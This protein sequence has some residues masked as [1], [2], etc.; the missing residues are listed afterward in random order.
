MQ[1]EKMGKWEE[2][3]GGREGG[4]EGGMEGGREGGREGG[5]EAGRE[6]KKE[7]EIG[8]LG[9]RE[10][11]EEREGSMCPISSK[12]LVISTLPSLSVIQQNHELHF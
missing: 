5:K 3:R 11:I 2:R 9:S 4:R 10:G 1:R 8:G 12:L 7:R 6:V